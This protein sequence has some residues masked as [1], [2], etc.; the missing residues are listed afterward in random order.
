MEYLKASRMRAAG[1]GQGEAAGEATRCQGRTYSTHRNLPLEPPPVSR[2]TVAPR[3]LFQAYRQGRT[4]CLGHS[5]GRDAHAGCRDLHDLFQDFVS[6]SSVKTLAGQRGHEL[7]AA[8]SGFGRCRFAKRQNHP[9][10]PAAREVRM[11][12]HGAGARRTRARIEQAVVAVR[13]MIAAKARHAP[14]P[15]TA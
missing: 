8:E 1:Q 14:G 12:V 5:N 7:D 10:D 2:E 15:T 9:A 6:A 11:G 3:Y 4:D 13:G